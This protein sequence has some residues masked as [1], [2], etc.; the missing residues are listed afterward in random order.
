VTGTGIKFANLSPGELNWYRAEIEKK[1]PSA[2]LLSKTE[3]QK[4]IRKK[5]YSEERQSAELA[6]IMRFIRDYKSQM[7]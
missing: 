1:Y 6:I 2:I 3:L 7:R 5:G 4:L